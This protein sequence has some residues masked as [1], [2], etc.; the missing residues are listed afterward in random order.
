MEQVKNWRILFSFFF[1][2]TISFVAYSCSDDDKS[3]TLQ[4]G[5]VTGIVTDEVGTPL[6]GVKVNISGVDGEATSAS[7]GE[8]T[9]NNVSVESHS[10][11]FSRTGRETVSTT[12]TSND[13]KHEATATVKI[14]MRDA[15]SIIQG[16]VYDAK[17]S[18]KPFAGVVVTLNGTKTSTTGSDGKFSFENIRTNDYSISFAKEGYTTISKSLTANSFKDKISIVENIYMG[19]VELLRGQTADDLAT[20]PKWYYNEYR[21]GRNADSYP[22][23]DWSTDYLSTQS[24]IGQW[25]E[26]NEGTTLQIRND[27]TNKANTADMDAFDSYIYGSKLITTENRIMSLRVRTHSTSDDAPA[28]FGVKVVDLSNSS[29]TNIGSVQTLHSENYKDFEF[30][31]SNYIGKEV[32]VAIGI[33]RQTTDENYYKQLV[34]R[35]IRFANEKVE[36]TN[37][38]PGT[39]VISGWKLSKETVKSTMIQTK[40]NFTGISKI[41]GNRDNY[42]DAYKSWPA[43][44]HIAAEWMFMPLKKDPEVFASEG[45]VIKTRNDSEVSSERPEAYMYAKFGVTSGSN[46]LTLKAR[47]FSNKYTYFK[48]TAIEGD[49]TITHLTPNVVNASNALAAADGCWK[50]TH[51]SGNSGDPAAYATFSYDLSQFNGKE[52]VIALGV[53]NCEANSGENKLSIYSIDLQ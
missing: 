25:A 13:F 35:A 39:E 22:H 26:Q 24:F 36:G 40:K 47:T 41:S 42:V 29:T 20:A 27:D 10:I 53:Y 11:V 37:W 38:L 49:G 51:E 43:I 15:S 34:L 30:D 3:S 2:V 4:S 31:L 21:G 48:F 17:N 52:V 8:F 32:I 12:V 18:N 45:Y 23:W 16:S 50:F 7:N 14:V 46:K 19:R 6:E 33:Y 28:Y 1:F 9:I 5:L 44:N